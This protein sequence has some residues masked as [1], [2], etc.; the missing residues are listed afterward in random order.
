E[1]RKPYA[2]ITGHA[3]FAGLDF[4]VDER[5]LVPRSPIAELIERGFEPWIE[6]ER[7]AHVLDLCTGSGCIGIACAYAFPE[8]GV[9][10]SD[11]SDDALAVARINAERL[12]VA[13]RVQLH[14]ADVFEGLPPQRYD[15]IVSNPPYVDAEDM[16]G[17][18]DEHRHEPALGL[19]AG[20]DGLD[21]VRRILADASHYLA[22]HGILVVEVGNSRWALEAAY[23]RVPFT[24][25][26]FERGQAEVFLLRAEQL[27]GMQRA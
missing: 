4:Q 17:L 12:H 3:R 15:I 5:V 8:A 9:D 24:W 25:L 16:A 27:D 26:E 11:V 21:I 18:P 6:P 7:V 2:Y 20:S 14:R 13:H 22:P 19:A 10:A 23:P 1:E